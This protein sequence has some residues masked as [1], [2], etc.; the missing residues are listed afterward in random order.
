MFNELLNH[1]EVAI[2]RAQTGGAYNIIGAYGIMARG[3]SF[4]VKGA[5]P[6]PTGKS[7]T[8]ISTGKKVRGTG[9]LFK[10]QMKPG[11]Y[12]YAKEVVRRIDYIENDYM[13]TLTQAFPTDIS[14]AVIPLV[15]EQQFYK[16]IKV[17][18]THASA[19]AIYQEAP[20]TPGNVEF[21]GGAPISYDATG[22][23][24]EIQVHK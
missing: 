6:I 1:P 18:N 19:D 9:T 2:F 20:I 10:S 12:I 24:L 5:I 14:V 4:P 23:E 17:K 21:S 7:G 13:L 3:S 22:S 8:I 11:D 15:C 16:A